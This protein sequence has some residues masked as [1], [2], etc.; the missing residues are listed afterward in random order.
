MRPVR[1]REEIDENLKQWEDTVERGSPMQADRVPPY[2]H[3]LGEAKARS[4]ER[5]PN[6]GPRGLAGRASSRSPTKLDPVR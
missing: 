2:R 1:F 3:L 5:R 4:A 6:L